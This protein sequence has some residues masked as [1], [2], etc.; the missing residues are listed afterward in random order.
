ML[1]ENSHEVMIIKNTVHDLDPRMDIVL[2]IR[3]VTMDNL[4]G[5]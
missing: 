2:T 4:E 1:D 5:Q 3:A